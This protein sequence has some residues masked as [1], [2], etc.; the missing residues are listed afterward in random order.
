MG[1]GM[2]RFRAHRVVLLGFGNRSRGE[3]DD[4]GEKLMSW[5]GGGSGENIRRIGGGVLK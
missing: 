1:E 2:L 4:G 5:D 3:V